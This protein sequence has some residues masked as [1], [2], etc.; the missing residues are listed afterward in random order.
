MKNP[1]ISCIMSVYN[2]TPQLENSIQSILDQTY[3]NFE[4]L[5]IDDGSSEDVL[6]V[7]DKYKKID[8][9]IKI[10]KNNKNIGLTKSLNI[11]INE[12]TGRYIARQDADDISDK[13]RFEKQ[14][15]FLKKNNYVGCTTLA[16]GLQSNKIL[17]LKSS[18]LPIKILLKFKNPFI[19]GTLMLSRK[20]IQDI[21]LYNEY[22]YFAQ[23]YKL[24]TDLATKGYRI[25]IIKKVLYKINQENNISNNHKKEQRAYAIKVKKSYK[26]YEN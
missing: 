16:R 13:K 24:F 12:S 10:L 22:F 5:I 8:N 25:K 7:L 4:F 23:D 2:R 26:F 11:L 14:L 20:V 18:L 21:G 9:R 19:H 17:R 15:K 1:T 3:T 6:E